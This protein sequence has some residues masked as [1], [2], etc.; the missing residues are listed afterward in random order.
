MRQTKQRDYH[1]PAD[2]YYN[3]QF[4]AIEKRLYY[5]PAN[6]VVYALQYLLGANHHQQLAYIG[7]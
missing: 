7:H 5:I 6:V 1:K 2:A 3:N 4:S